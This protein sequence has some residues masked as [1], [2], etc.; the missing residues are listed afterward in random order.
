[1]GRGAGADQLLVSASAT[2]GAAA[3]AAIAAPA[4]PAPTLRGGR[5]FSNY[6]EKNSKGEF[7]YGGALLKIDGHYF[8]DPDSCSIDGMEMPTTT[9][10][11]GERVYPVELDPR[12]AHPIASYYYALAVSAVAP[13]QSASDL[14]A[15]LERMGLNKMWWGGKDDMKTRSTIREIR[16][17]TMLPF[18]SRA[19]EDGKTGFGFARSRADVEA[20]RENRTKRR[21]SAT[22]VFVKGEEILKA[23][24]AGEGWRIGWQERYREFR[25]TLNPA[26]AKICDALI[27]ALDGERVKGDDLATLARINDDKERSWSGSSS[28]R[29]L[30]NRLRSAGAPICATTGAD[31]G[32]WIAEVPIEYRSWLE[33][34]YGERFEAEEA[35]RRDLK[36]AIS[37]WDPQTDKER[38]VRDQVCRGVIAVGS[39]PALAPSPEAIE[40]INK[41]RESEARF[42]ARNA[43]KLS[44]EEKARQKVAGIKATAAFK[45]G[46]PKH[47]YGFFDQMTEEEKEAVAAY[48]TALAGLNSASHA[49]R[50]GKKKSSGSRTRSRASKTSVKSYSRKPSSGSDLSGVP[51][52][53]PW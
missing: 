43:P 27:T 6:A 35:G 21:A 1:M 23:A 29:P 38:S 44:K 28:I 4:A 36:R 30:I 47:S 48:E 9:H 50:N 46:W 33:D 8:L 7:L 32:Y 13:I 22:P 26:D 52:K 19:G 45:T 37:F 16:K 49:R 42:R 17:Q 12:F 5:R 10:P 20:D 53:A 18:T 11:C 40:R 51:A 2:R 15:R 34:S 39:A 3:T 31:K 24:E 14:S 41:V 25:K